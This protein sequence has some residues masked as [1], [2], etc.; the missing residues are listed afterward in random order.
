MHAG[1]RFPCNYFA[2]PWLMQFSKK[3]PP[4]EKLKTTLFP[5]VRNLP[6]A[7]GR[8]RSALNARVTSKPLN[9]SFFG[10]FLL[11]CLLASFWQAFKI[12]HGQKTR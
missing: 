5:G 3:N 1:K 12:N 10:D 11:A 7:S 4:S 8:F 9:F 2:S 6:S